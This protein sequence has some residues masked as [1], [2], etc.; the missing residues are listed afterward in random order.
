MKQG[1]AL[2]AVFGALLVGSATVLYAFDDRGLTYGLL[3]GAGLASWLTAFCIH[4][5]RRRAP[6]FDVDAARPLPATSWPSAAV[7][8]G[9]SLMTLGVLFGLF[10][11]LIGAGVVVAGLGGLVRER[12]AM[13]RAMREAGA[14]REA[15]AMRGGALGAALAI[16]VAVAALLAA[17]ASGAPQ[18]AAAPGG[19]PT[20]QGNVQRGRA[21]FSDSCASC[22]GMNLQGIP[23]RAPKLRGVGALAAD[24]YVRT[25]RMPLD[26]PGDE[27]L[28]RRSAFKSS[29]IDAIVAYISTFGGPPIPK[30]D[31]ARGVLSVGQKAFAS[32]CAGCHQ[33]LAEGGLVTKARVPRIQGIAP[34]QVGEAVRTGPF[35]MPPFSEYTIDQRQ[36]NSIAR[37]L[38]YTARPED[39][40]GWSIG[41]LGPVPEGMVAWLIGLLALVLIIRLLGERVEGPASEPPTGTVPRAP[42]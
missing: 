40:G 12:R 17:G 7:G 20:F 41:H 35:L 33:I 25:G 2:F 34:T 31:P 1:T 42:E 14:L 39:R 8:V 30:V 38:Q 16:A 15:G 21:L 11:V 23:G 37:Y 36:L 6:D 24:F 4:A 13:A 26:K 32:N 9:A 18:L 10:M 28:R 29:D 22:H 3:G 27:P 5:T 19:S